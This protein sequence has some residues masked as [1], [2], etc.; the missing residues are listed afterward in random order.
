[1]SIRMSVCLSLY[2]SVRFRGKCD[3]SGCNEDRGQLFCVESLKYYTTADNYYTDS[4]NLNQPQK[5]P[6]LS[7]ILE[8]LI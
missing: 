1:M 6:P 5:S 4:S 7:E 2:L 8:P 3:F